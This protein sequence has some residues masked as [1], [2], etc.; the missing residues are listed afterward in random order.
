MTANKM[1]ITVLHS[2]F[3]AKLE[4]QQMTEQG[5]NLPKIVIS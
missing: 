2:I 4:N 3:R 5:E 1:S